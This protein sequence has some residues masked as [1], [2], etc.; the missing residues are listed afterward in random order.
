MPN[1]SVRAAAEGMPNINRRR[2]M[3]GAGAT[4]A[5]LAV[6]SLPAESASHPDEALFII[7]KEFDAAEQSFRAALDTC[8]AAEKKATEAAGPKPVMLSEWEETKGKMPVDIK[9]IHDA[10]LMNVRLGDAMNTKEWHPE[11]VRAYY[12]ARAEERAAIKAAWDAFAAKRDEFFVQFDC[13]RLEKE[14]EA[15]FE[16]VAAIGDRI[17]ETPAH[18]IEGMAVKVRAGKVL[19]L[20]D[21]AGPDE[22]LASIAEDIER[23]S[24]QGVIS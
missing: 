16:E 10:A 7:E 6:T 5:A 18:T 12:D 23:L 15:R 3:L 19:N 17:F 1:T 24:T 4:A 8:T 20:D 14:W 13:K 9:E 2:A 11:P 22:V 21:F